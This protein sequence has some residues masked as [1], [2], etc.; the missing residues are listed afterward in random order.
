MRLDETG[1]PAVIDVNPNNDIHRDAGLA[2]AAR[3]VGVDYEAL[4][5]GVVEVARG[6]PT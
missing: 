4:I 5:A 6:E 2:A 3:S 1:R